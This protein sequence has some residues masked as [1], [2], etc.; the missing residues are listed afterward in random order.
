[1]HPPHLTAVADRSV[2][3]LG[4]ALVLVADGG[5]AESS[6]S[7]L[8][9]AEAN[10]AAGLVA[11]GIPASWIGRVGDDAY[12]SLIRFELRRRGVDVG[13]VETDPERPTG[14]YHKRT[15]I[16]AD[17]D[18]TSESSYHRLGSAASA[19]DLAF[20]DRSETRLALNGAAVV[21]CS[22]ITAALSDSCADL[23][24]RLLS[25]RPDMLATVSFDVNWREQLWLDGDQ[26]IVVELAGLADI[27]LV[28]AD[29]AVR[30]FGSDDP[31][32]LRRIL[33]A[34]HTVV[35]KDGSRRA[36]AVDVDG[37]IVSVP[38]LTVDVIEPVGA[39]DAFAA[40]YL[41]GVVLGEDPDR[42]LRRGHIGAAATLTVVSDSASPPPDVV[43]ELLF[44]SEE[45]WAATT[46]DARGFAV[47]G[48][49]EVP[50]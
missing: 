5:S 39:G 37:G 16:G 15:V 7:H 32:T 50:I 45:I 12:G 41:A 36:V 14:Y 24:R 29:E 4:E 25:G 11:Q 21:H 34:P 30:V 22:G 38:A 28:G 33:P 42:C 46:V 10:V 47:P 49:M 18:P 20:L 31:S 9:G 1:M 26:S 13:A 6:T 17:G 19:M 23:M 43:A 3:C 2:V 35:I 27:V 48:S 44:C 40:G 8:G